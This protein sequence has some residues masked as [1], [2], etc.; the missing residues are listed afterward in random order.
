M[1]NIRA[2]T[3]SKKGLSCKKKVL[4]VNSTSD[5]FYRKY[6]NLDVNSKTSIYPKIT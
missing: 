1:R 6:E 4:S 3:T 2:G 5:I